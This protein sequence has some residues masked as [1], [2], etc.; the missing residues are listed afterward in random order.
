MHACKH[1][2]AWQPCTAHARRRSRCCRARPQARSHA[3]G[4]SP[5]AAQGTEKY[6]PDL[7]LHVLDNCS[8]WVQQ[9]RWEDTNRLMRAFFAAK[10]LAAPAAAPARAVSA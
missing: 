4:G 9:E 2:P 3:S 6:V 5:G 8:H 7:D 10:P 1:G